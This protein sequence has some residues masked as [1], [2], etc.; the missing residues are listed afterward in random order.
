[1]GNT[2]RAV[3]HLCDTPCD[4][5]AKELTI[6]ARLNVRHYKRSL[7]CFIA[8]S[9]F[10]VLTANEN[11]LFREKNKRV[12]CIYCSPSPVAKEI[13]PDTPLFV[14]EMNN[15]TN[16]I[17]GIGLVKNRP[18]VGKYGVYQHSE[19]NRF[20][21]IGSMRIDRGEWTEYETEIMRFFD[22]TCFTGSKHMKRG[23]GITCYPTEMLYRCLPLFNLTEFIQTMFKQRFAS[24][25]VRN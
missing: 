13:L 18:I 9:R 8:T 7:R 14:L 2:K 5:V 12:A 19:Y 16:K 10:T 11:R 1:M 25:T 3:S 15:D 6:Q 23:N 24:N 21:Y 20:V 22:I 17:V 4:A